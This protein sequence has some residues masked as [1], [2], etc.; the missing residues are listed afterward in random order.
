MLGAEDALGEGSVSVFLCDCR[1]DPERE[2][3]TFAHYFP[4]RLTG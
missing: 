3:V 1:D 2:P 4:A